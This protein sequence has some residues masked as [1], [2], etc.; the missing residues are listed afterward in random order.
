MAAMHVADIKYEDLRVVLFGSGTAGTGI[1]D[2][3]KDAIAMDT[4]KSKEEAGQ[5]IWCVD[6]PGLL[7]QSHG[8]ALTPSQR[9]YARSENGWQKKDSNSLFDVV[10][11]VKPHVLIG[12]ST[13][14]KAFTREIVQEMASHVQRPI[15][16]PLSNPTSL[17]EATPKDLVDWTEGRVLTATGSPFDAVETKGKMRVIAECNNSTVFPGIGLGVVLS[18]ARLITSKML[19]SAVKALAAQ[20]PA[21]QDDEAGLLPDVTNV[22]EISVKVAAAVIK[23][24]VEDSLAQE[25]NIPSDDEVLH[26]WIKEQMWDAQYRPLKKVAK[27]EA[28]RAALGEMGSKGSVTRN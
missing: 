21:L 2:Q 28:S 18:R 5:Q 11:A 12:T 25:T 16:F 4:D 20:A 7:L 15:I 10:R 22:R 19:V 6:K 14:P 13:Q 8:E 17:H 27:E 26:E 23:Q 24:A 9:D 1:A 3:L